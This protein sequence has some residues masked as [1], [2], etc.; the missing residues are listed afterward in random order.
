MAE[1]HAPIVLQTRAKF[2]VLLHWQC[3][4]T[5]RLCD[6]AGRASTKRERRR[7]VPEQVAQQV[8]QF[9][10]W[11][12]SEERRD[13]L[14]SSAQS[15]RD[16]RSGLHLQ[17][18]Q[19]MSRPDPAKWRR[20]ADRPPAAGPLCRPPSNSSRPGPSA[21]KSRL[22][23]A[24]A[25]GRTVGPDR[26]AEDPPAERRRQYDLER[27]SGSKL[28]AR[29]MPPY[30]AVEAGCRQDGGAGAAQD[31]HQ[32]APRAV[33]PANDRTRQPPSGPHHRPRSD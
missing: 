30:D 7:E 33:G 23:A 18:P 22:Q 1:A 21:V 4:R 10:P 9:D 13:Q 14:H 12:S 2:E 19:T 15:D 5:D 17:V 20:S 24:I 28:C 25:S 31:G 32:W 29:G 8:R 6:L 26:R 11:P 27:P 16:R 3:G